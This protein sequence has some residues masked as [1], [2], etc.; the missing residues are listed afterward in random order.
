MATSSAV[1]NSWKEI[2]GYLHCG[3]RTAQRWETRY[4][5]PIMRIGGEERGAVTAFSY[6]LDAWLSGHPIRKDGEG[7]SPTWS[8]IAESRRLREE[9]T[10]L[11]T[12]NR[13]ALN[14]LTHNILQLCRLDVS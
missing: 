7:R 4:G 5:L 2:S 11:R 10:L 6:D 8:L 13:A 1:L 9:A 3:V 12:E 14:R